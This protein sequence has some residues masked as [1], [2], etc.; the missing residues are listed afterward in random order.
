MFD[1]S[2]CLGSERILANPTRVETRNLSGLRCVGCLKEIAFPP[3]YPQN[4]PNL[5]FGFGCLVKQLNDKR[6]NGCVK[7][8]PHTNC[9]NK[10]SNM[11]IQWKI[12]RHKNKWEQMADFGV[13]CPN[14]LF[15]KQFFYLK[16][17]RIFK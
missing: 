1:S 3:V 12:I 6:F 11:P 13:K 17:L 9:S 15:G 7:D 8:C 5:V 16:K 2:T 4:H 10:Q 14:H